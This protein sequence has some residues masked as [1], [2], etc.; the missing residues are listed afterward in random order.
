MPQQCR[1]IIEKAMEM[2]GILDLSESQSVFNSIP[3]KHQDGS[4]YVQILQQVLV[5]YLYGF[6]KDLYGQAPAVKS[7]ITRQVD[8]IIKA[9]Q[10]IEEPRVIGSFSAST[11][12][13]VP[14]AGYRSS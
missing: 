5:D 13:S 1:V 12:S 8:Q 11:A 2:Q 4:V 14:K 3:N 7:Q 9:N 6:A 10:K